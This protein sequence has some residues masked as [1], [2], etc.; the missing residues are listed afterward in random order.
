MVP[1]N[2][3]FPKK[4]L[5]CT[6]LLCTEDKSFSDCCQGKKRERKIEFGFSI[7]GWILSLSLL[8]SKGTKSDVKVGF[9][10]LSPTSRSAERPST[11]D[12]KVERRE[13]DFFNGSQE[14]RNK[15]WRDI[16]RS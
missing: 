10:I 8:S 13:E 5:D 6:T 9:Q 1:E 12:R 4:K 3:D 7:L 11:E 15:G 2:V 16:T 14:K